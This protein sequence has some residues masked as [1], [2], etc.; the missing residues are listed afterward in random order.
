MQVSAHSTR[1]TSARALTPTTVVAAAGDAFLSSGQSPGDRRC[2]L[3]SEFVLARG[4]RL[5]SAEVACRLA[6][7]PD[8][9]VVAVL[10]GIS[11]TRHVVADAGASK[12]GWWSD[13]VGERRGVDTGRFRVLSV[14]WLGGVGQ[15]TSPRAGERFPFVDASDQARALWHVCDALGVGRL[16]A[17][18]GASYGGMVALHAAGQQPTRVDRLA[19]IAASHRS[20]PQASAWRYLQRC[21][22]ELGSRGGCGDEALALAR[23]LAMTTYR[24]A[25]ELGERFA[26]SDGIDELQSWLRARG[27]AFARSWNSEQFLCLNRSIDNHAIDPAAVVVPTWLLAFAS[28]Q[29]VPAA[30]VRELAWQLPQLRGYREMHTRFGHDAFLKEGLRV[31]AVLRRVLA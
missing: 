20:H 25:T 9:P 4:G 19:V 21:I 1:S 10:G 5:R 14:D 24:T 27:V 16:H 12:R 22:V 6:G 17:V 8:A 13:V 3:P 28:D 26:E 30:D 18:V 7:A 23:S 29:L 31:S 2:P 15:S 11:A